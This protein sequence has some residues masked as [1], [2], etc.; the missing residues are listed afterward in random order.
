MSFATEAHFLEEVE[1]LFHS[2][3]AGGTPDVF[4]LVCSN[5]PPIEMSKYKADTYEGEL[6]ST[7][8]AT[9]PLL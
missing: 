8:W 3:I 2:D 4:V 5:A 7:K 6:V 9:K 1:S